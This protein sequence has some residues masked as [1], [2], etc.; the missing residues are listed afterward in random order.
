MPAIAYLECSRC[1][2]H[3]S[4]ETPQTLCPVC[5][6]PPVGS[7]YV[8]YDFS[9]LIGSSPD[10]FIVPGS[11]AWPSLG[12]WR[13]GAVLPDVEPVTLGEGWTPM[14]QGARAGAGGDDGEALR[15]EETRR[16]FGGECGWGACCVCR[17]GGDGG[18][19]LHAEG[20]AVCKLC[21]GGCLW[22]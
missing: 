4:A 7:L 5:L 20:C 3:V 16:A 11:A 8:R 10:D 18:A 9:S 12:M 17:G 19:Y 14:L 2:A 6:S 15:I 13:Y 22:R 1:G 21:G